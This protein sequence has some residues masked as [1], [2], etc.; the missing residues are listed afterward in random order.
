MRGALRWLCAMLLGLFFMTT[1]KADPKEFVDQAKRVRVPLEKQRL[2]RS[3]LAEDPQYVEA[4]LLLG[5]SQYLDTGDI[6]KAV[7]NFTKV[8]A[9][10]KDQ[11]GYAQGYLDDIDVLFQT[12]QI[13]LMDRRVSALGYI[14][15]LEYR[16]RAPRSLRDDQKTR[17]KY[18]EANTSE[19]QINAIDA[20]DD[21]PMIEVD[22]FP[23]VIDLGGQFSNYSITL[24]VK[25]RPGRERR[26]RFEFNE[27]VRDPVEILWDSEWKLIERVPSEFV[28]IE[29][30]L[31]YSMEPTPGVTHFALSDSVGQVE[32]RYIAADAQTILVLRNSQEKD[33]E[34]RYNLMVKIV[35]GVAAVIGLLGTR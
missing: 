1:A 18:L 32:G 24:G 26:Y 35:M 3:A 7:E 14:D 30:P 8:L 4:L 21:R 28:K 17:L 12:L 15:G 13:K 10:G 9:L 33:K 25:N 29:Y 5:Q 34:K 11:D 16:I 2:L 20:G 6:R 22:Y 19:F 23:V 31:K 27:D